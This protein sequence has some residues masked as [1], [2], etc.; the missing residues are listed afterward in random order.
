[1]STDVTTT[2]AATSAAGATEPQRLAALARARIKG[3]GA[4]GLGP[5]SHLA[6]KRAQLAEQRWD[7]FDALPQSPTIGAEI[8]GIDLAGDLSDDAID[9]IRRALLAYKVL[10]F[11][12]Q[13]LSAA[14]QVALARRFGELEV[15]P[16]LAG[17]D[18]APELVRLAKDAAV[19]GY[20]NIWHSD[21]SWREQPA[22]GAILRAVEVPSVGGDTLFA[23]MAAA[24]EGLDDDVKARIEGAVAVHD[25]VLS[26]GQALGPS[27]REAARRQY[28]AVE[29]PIV[30]TH[31]ETGERILY[32]NAIFTSHVVGLD[33]DDS[34]ALLDHLFRQAEVPEVQYRLRWAPGTVAFWDNRATQHYASSDYWPQ[35]RVMERAAI[36]GDR[37]R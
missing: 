33:E 5:H 23:D 13:D 26:F 6:E 32:V 14:Q 31:P 17:S 7:G 36:A 29:H 10:V 12:D 27:E 8:S 25:F 16:F 24:Y 34:E 3:R 19:G 1:M 28:P 18:E 21:V 35:P 37:P 11:R 30:R 20:E 15:H 9:E 2:P 22:L 4:S